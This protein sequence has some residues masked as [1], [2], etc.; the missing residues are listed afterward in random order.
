VPEA[1]SGGHAFLSYVHEDAADVDYVERKLQAAGIPVWRD[2]ANLWPGEDWRARIREAI[3]RDAL[4]FIACFSKRSVTRQ[5]TYMNYELLLALDE[6]RSRQPG[7]PWLIPVCFDDCPVPDYDL[8]GGRTLGGL[9]RANLY[10]LHRDTQADRLVA[11]VRRRLERP[12]ADPGPPAAPAEGGWSAR[13]LGPEPPLAQR[14]APERPAEAPGGS[15][16]GAELALEWL[17]T[18]PVPAGGRYHSDG[19]LSYEELGAALKFWTP[20]W[21]LTMPQVCLGV[22]QPGPLQ[23]LAL[24][25]YGFDR[26]VVR[27][28]C[29]PAADFARLGLSRQALYESVCNVDLPVGDG[30]PAVV[31]VV[32]G[33]PAAP[34]RDRQAQQ[35]AALLEAGDP[36]CILG[37]GN[38]SVA[39]RLGFIDAVIERL[40]VATPSTLAAATWVNTKARPLGPFQL[41]FGG[42]PGGPAEPG[43]TE[44]LVYWDGPEAPWAAPRSRATGKAAGKAAGHAAPSP[45][46]VNID[47][48]GETGPSTFSPDGS[49]LAFGADGN[50][51]VADAG[52]GRLLR[53]LPGHHGRVT[54][55]ACSCDGTLLAAGTSQGTVTVWDPA[56]G[57]R[58]ATLTG[59]SAVTALAFSRDRSLATGRY[60]GA[61]AVWDIARGSERT[62]RGALGWVQTVAFS[63]DGTLLA[64]TSH[65]TIKPGSDRWTDGEVSIRDV[66]TDVSVCRLDNRNGDAGPTAFSPDGR[67]AAVGLD[68]GVLTFDVRTGKEHGRLPA[69]A[70]TVLAVA[71]SADASVVFVAA[72]RAPATGGVYLRAWDTLRGGARIRAVMERGEYLLSFSLDAHMVVGGGVSFAPGASLVAATTGNYA[73]IS[74]TAGEGR[75]V[76][77]YGPAKTGIP[78]LAR[79]GTRIASH[80]KGTT[81]VWDVATVTRVTAINASAPTGEGT[82][83][84]LSANGTLAAVQDG[85]LVTRIWD[86]AGNWRGALATG[87]DKVNRL[88]FL[89]QGTLAAGQLSADMRLRVWDT[90]TGTVRRTLTRRRD[91]PLVWAFSADGKRAVI[92]Y[93]A[94]STWLADV[95]S[96]ARIALILRHPPRDK[97]ESRTGSGLNWEFSLNAAAFSGDGRLLAGASVQAMG[98]DSDGPA[99]I[100]LWN[101]DGIGRRRPRWPPFLPELCRLGGPHGTV[102]DLA[103]SHDG[104]RLAAGCHDGT[105]W[106]WRVADG[107]GAVSPVAHGAPVDSV[108]FSADTRALVTVARDG[109]VRYLDPATGAALADRVPLSDGGLATLRSDGCYRIDGE[110]S[111][112]LWW[113]VGLRRFSAGEL[114]GRFAHIQRLPGNA[115]VITGPPGGFPA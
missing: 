79:D 78:V 47:P 115:P 16:A 38:V 83:L 7:D 39:N 42:E 33:R 65:G 99:V 14:A 95:A 46:V 104:E 105:V 62:L 72:A 94:G 89:G 70:G 111:D 90:A 37:A 8:G 102:R 36:V 11:A 68:G 3:T 108:V 64:V 4:V 49:L 82:L 74:D 71:F 101:T 112:H 59:S 88:Q 76:T 9:H 58:V 114:D 24:V 34:R 51:K 56:S 57:A 100:R 97:A 55:V 5:R 107:A 28:F 48:G 19:V 106:I 67:L 92:Y 113:S 77:V 13:P 109:I 87:D 2:T 73:Q 35:V 31:N 93:A 12:G 61:V 91:H 41:Y 96:G 26:N 53:V 50:V 25:I 110:A 6:L 32:P 45:A 60:D 75:L 52:T 30:A 10:G 69:S 66:R 27:M 1:T 85:N 15:A 29:L 80:A 21:G 103:F 18:G 43:R 98:F 40:P 22:V 17:V 86:T 23:Y 44:R 54:A 20:G 81:H 84:A 63:P